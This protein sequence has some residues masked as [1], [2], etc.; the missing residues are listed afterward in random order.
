MAEPADS[1]KSDDALHL[2]AKAGNLELVRSFLALGADPD[3]R[4]GEQ[5]ETPLMNAA[6]W[7]RI[8]VA[9]LLITAGASVNSK[10]EEAW[11]AL[12]AACVG[13]EDE[14]VALLLSHGA[15]PTV[16]SYDRAFD[17]Q[18]GWHFLGTPLHIAA[19]NGSVKVAEQLLAKGALV[20]QA[21]DA[22]QRTPIFYAAAYGHADILDLLC[23]HGADP[24]G[25]EH[26]QGYSAFC[27]NTPLHY[28][29][30][31]GH[32]EATRVLL[33]H[34]ADPGAKE[35]SLGHTAIQMASA[36]HP[37]VVDL[38]LEHGKQQAMNDDD[39][40]TASREEPLPGE[41]GSAPVL[42]ALKPEEEAFV[43]L[44]SN[45]VR[46]LLANPSISARDVHLCGIM[47]RALER[48]PLVTEGVGLS[49]S[50]ISRSSADGN[51]WYM[52]VALDEESFRLS[53]GET[54]YLPE[55]GSDHE[56]RMIAE[57]GVG[58]REDEA[59]HV[60]LEEWASTFAGRAA[61]P[62]IEIDIEDF[63]NSEVDWHDDTTGEDYW[64]DLESDY[65]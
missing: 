32:V 39:D 11:T 14:M 7:K 23:K 13:K 22:D 59:D 29:A 38:L 5:G 44:L 15:D 10:T 56:S 63:G 17:E 30:Q 20:N 43:G 41:P 65:S 48:L 61:D 51:S 34:G 55:T 3:M 47:L 6:R 24:N 46:T 36:R 2:A 25:R 31:N 4:K 9:C 45:A 1:N 28:A 58:W 53:E 54:Y 64:G 12:H 8:D 37:K 60:D 16:Y 33:A 57:I 21:W 40:E 19:A 62:A 26:R 18:L 49:L 50:L 35:S 42:Y 27:D 52:E